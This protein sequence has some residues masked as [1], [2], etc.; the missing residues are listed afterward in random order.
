MPTDGRVC[1][2]ALD[3]VE[4]N[5]VRFYPSRYAKT[6]LD[7]LGEKSR[8]CVSAGNCGGGIDTDLSERRADSYR[9]SM[10]SKHD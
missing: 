7:W 8:D 1:R 2:W 10:T 4:T 6:Y 3:A 5:C 9:I